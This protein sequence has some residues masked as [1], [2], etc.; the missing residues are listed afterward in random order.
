[1]YS[2]TTDQEWDTSVSPM[3]AKT[4][5]SG[6]D[7]M[8]SVSLKAVLRSVQWWTHSSLGVICLLCALCL[9]LDIFL[10]FA[11]IANVKRMFPCLQNWR[12]FN[13]LTLQ[14]GCINVS[15]GNCQ[16]ILSHMKESLKQWRNNRVQKLTPL[17]IKSI[18]SV[19]LTCGRKRSNTSGREG[20]SVKAKQCSTS[21]LQ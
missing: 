11:V 13:L 2:K 16:D 8:E 5:S 3:E 21:L 7:G 15:H 12:T 6:K 18:P 20:F 17:G 9:E 1:M 14:C 19:L 4:Q 10:K